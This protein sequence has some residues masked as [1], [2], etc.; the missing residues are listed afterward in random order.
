MTFP[1]SMAVAREIVLP[2]GVTGRLVA[3][4]HRFELI[5]SER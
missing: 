3:H 2:S 5:G 4:P 1:H